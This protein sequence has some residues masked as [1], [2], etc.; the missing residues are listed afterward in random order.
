MDK[1]SVSAEVTGTVCDYDRCNCACDQCHDSGIMLAP[2]PCDQCKE[3]RFGGLKFLWLEDLQVLDAAMRECDWHSDV[4]DAI[5]AE[6]E[7]R[8]NE[9]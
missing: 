6:L 7:R 3:G 1:K 2:V 5:E 4:W 9:R 8:A